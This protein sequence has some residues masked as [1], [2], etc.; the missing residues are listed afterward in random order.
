MDNLHFTQASLEDYL[1]CPRRYQLRYLLS[2]AWPAQVTEPEGAFEVHL[3]QGAALHR[4]IQQDVLGIDRSH[5][6]SLASEEPL[7]TWWASYVENPVSGLPETRLP[8]LELSTDIDGQRLVGKFDMLAFERGGRFVIVDWKTARRVPARE[9]LSSRMQTILYPYLLARSGAF[10]NG[11]VPIS[12]E[13]I[14][15]VYWFTE[16]PHSPYRFSYN[17]HLHESNE[18]MLKSV[19]TEIS[20]RTEAIYPLT[21]DER[22]CGFCNYRSLCKRGVKAGDFEEFELA[23]EGFDPYFELDLD[24]LPEIPF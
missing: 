8:E 18:G 21:S 24:S 4:L 14:E 2:Q 11:G 15:M 6:D 22:K 3:R 23:M 7:R 17:Q 16:L 13:Q 5:L 12:P 20:S 1:A 9:R 10:M 19:L